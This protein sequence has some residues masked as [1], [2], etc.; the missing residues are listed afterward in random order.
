MLS[1][2]DRT[3]VG[4]NSI[5]VGSEVFLLDYSGQS[6]SWMLPP[7]DDDTESYSFELDGESWFQKC[8][9]YTVSTIRHISPMSPA[10]SKVICD[11]IPEFGID[12]HSRTSSA[13]VDRLVPVRFRPGDH[14]CV[15]TAYHRGETPH[16]TIGL[17][18]V[19]NHRRRYLIKFENG[20]E[21]PQNTV[22]RSDH[23]RAVTGGW[24]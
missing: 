18:W 23:H 13:D 17:A 2:A 24:P 19:E 9:I 11:L 14:V 16:G 6:V 21:R 8:N 22:A 5:S 3:L 4:H 12:N 7:V 10:T 20:N 1:F 15:Y